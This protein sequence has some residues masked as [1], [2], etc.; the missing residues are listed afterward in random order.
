MSLIENKSLDCGWGKLLF[1]ETYS[2]TEK[3][4]A[5]LKKERK[6]E[7]NILFYPL[8]PQIILTQYP[9]DFFLNPAFTYKIDLQ[10][11]SLRRSARSTFSIRKA[12]SVD[13]V[14]ALN[15]VYEKMKMQ[16]LR[17]NWWE[18]KDEAITLYIVEDN[19]NSEILGGVM[20]ID[21]VHAFK[22]AKKSVSLWSLVVSSDARY[23]GIGKA[24]MKY[25][26]QENKRKKR[27][28]L[29]LSVVAG[30]IPAQRLYETLGFV[31][32]PILTVKNKS[33]I[34]ESLFVCQR[35]VQKFSPHTQGIIREALK[36]GIHVEQIKDDVYKL[37]LGGRGLLCNSSLSE[38][39]S[40]IMQL[41]CKDQKQFFNILDILKVQ[42]PETLFLGKRTK[43]KDFLDTHSRIILKTPIKRLVSE[44]IATYSGLK[45]NFARIHSVSSNVLVQKYEEGGLYRLLVFG[46]K[47]VA[48]VK[49]EP[50]KIIGNGKLS[51][52]TLIKK[53]SRRKIALSGGENKIPLDSGTRSCILKQG[54]TLDDILPKG[55]ELWVRKTANYHKGGTLIDITDSFPDYFKKIATK[56]SRKLQI[57]VLDIEMI[58][59][60][61]DEEE[62][63]V[64]EANVKPNLSYYSTQNVYEKFLDVI[65][66]R[67]KR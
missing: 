53:Q 64:L 62:Y 38:I 23:P 22:D 56:I 34:N 65:F 50:P 24:L 2:K 16:P 35:M 51:I 8:D 32:T 18:T 37:T 29:F 45:K 9:Q 4:V 13:D 17:K 19:E 47:V 20:I 43:A 5:D 14:N 61:L 44:E 1:G 33:P 6:K 41:M 25:V 31:R 27:K 11:F 12:E 58:I 39:T 54:Y 49:S 59:P 26:I 40:S 60:D 67:T 57:S 7:R 52:R 55:E 48:V 30:N 46:G 66:P 3:S 15:E 42:Y 10:S 28:R 21:H 36:R 63:F